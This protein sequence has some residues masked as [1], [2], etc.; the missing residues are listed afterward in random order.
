ML[1]ARANKEK[2]IYS[3]ITLNSVTLEKDADLQA[4]GGHI[5]AIILDLCKATSCK[6][7]A[8]QGLVYM[9]QGGPTP[10]RA[11][12]RSPSCRRRSP[13]SRPR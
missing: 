5:D 6:A 10:I 3:T 1:T 4:R 7:D 2:R 11:P 12:Q 13:R 8:K 9:A